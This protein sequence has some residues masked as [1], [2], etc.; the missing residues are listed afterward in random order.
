MPS[1]SLLIKNKTSA[2]L[3]N[4]L[5]KKSYSGHF[6]LVDDNTANHCLPILLKEQSMLHKAEVIEI[7]SGE[8]FKNIE[9]V[10][11]MEKLSEQNADRNAVLINLGGGVV[12]DLGGF[13]AAAY[14]RGIDFIHIPTTLLAMVDAAHGGKQGIDF[15]HFK[16]QIGVFQMP[17]GVVV[18][19]MYL[20]TLPEE[21][22]Q[23]GFAEVVKHRLLAGDDYWKKISRI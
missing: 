12:C 20:K 11:P 3:T 6:I 8:E 17:F 22:L 13:A 9:T 10:Q 15:M 4:F 2:A 1:S 5:R 21:Q 7:F 19:V 16:N 14:K 23:N 18:D